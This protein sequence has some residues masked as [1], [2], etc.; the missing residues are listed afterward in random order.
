M[1]S[2]LLSPI[3]PPNVL[4]TSYTLQGG[5]RGK[6]GP[7]FHCGEMLLLSLGAAVSF[8]CN[9]STPQYLPIFLYCLPVSSSK[10]RVCIYTTCIFTLLLL[11]STDTAASACLKR[12]A[13][14]YD[15]NALHP[16]A[17]S[18]DEDLSDF[19]VFVVSFVSPIS[20][21]VGMNGCATG[22]DKRHHICSPFPSLW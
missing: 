7:P 14:G 20:L 19:C 16:A 5:E 18:V 9:L 2:A 6:G 15:F 12:H 8:T 21:S 17:E 13:T 22:H 1:I 4:H 11:C 10:V 3:C